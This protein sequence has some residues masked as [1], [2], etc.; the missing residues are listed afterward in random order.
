MSDLKV[1]VFQICS[2]DS[3]ED[4]SKKILELLKVHD[5]KS[6]DLCV[7]PENSLYINI[8]KTAKTPEISFDHH[9]FDAAKKLAQENDV[10][11]HLG[12]MPVYRGGKLFNSTILINQKGELSEAYDKIHLFAA[13]LGPA[14]SVDEG[15]NYSPGNKPAV[16]DVKGWTVGLSICF[17]LRF[18]ELYLQYAKEGCELI[19]VPSAFFRKTGEAHW[20]T[21]LKARAIESQCYV[22][23]PGQVGT[24]KSVDSEAIRKSYGHSI[25][26]HPW[27]N[28]IED[29][30][31]AKE[32]VSTH[33]LKKEEIQKFKSSVKMKRKL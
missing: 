29:M 9:F 13:D 19:L 12:T 24:H 8:D 7:F 31:G 27:G 32:K 4:N 14:L 18:P 3:F 5:L 11:L 23:A 16:I 17:D 15:V 28:L 25:F 22:V 21:L 26:V 20:E 6:V 10:L 1:S 30:G 2:N 33:T